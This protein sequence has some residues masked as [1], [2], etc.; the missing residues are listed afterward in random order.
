MAVAMYFILAPRFNTYLYR[1]L[2]FFPS[3]FPS[4]FPGVPALEGIAGEDVYFKG[5]MGQTL[6]GWYFHRPDSEYHILFSH[7]NSGN[8]TIR[9]H[10]SKLMLRSGYSVFVYDYQGFGRSSGLPTIHGICSDGEAAYDYLVNER[11]VNPDKIVFYGESLGCSVAAHLSTVKPCRGLI[12]QS[13]FASLVRIACLHF[14]WLHLYPS[15]L[16]PKPALDN[17][18]IVREAKVPILFIHGDL[19]RVIPVQHA[20]DMYEA[21]AGVKHFVRLPGTAHGDVW[22]T[23]EK[24]Y[25]EALESFPKNF[26]AVVTVRESE[27][28][29]A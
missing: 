26:S 9:H 23:A 15:A 25:V 14:P 13:G 11:G 1:S 7:G 29:S 17:L 24:E 18:S 27:R 2:L 10:L 22:S 19:D 12:M 4:D 28:T 6:N 21:A 8:L 3:R 16:Y 20:V 5:S